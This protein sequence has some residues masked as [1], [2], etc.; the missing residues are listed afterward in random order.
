MSVISSVASHQ[1]QSGFS[2]GPKKFAGSANS[3]VV[4]LKT[5]KTLE[6]NV[7]MEIWLVVELASV[8][9]S[10]NVLLCPGL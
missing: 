2:S 9:L 8:C 1:E 6:L 5:V 10:V 7:K 3:E 4:R